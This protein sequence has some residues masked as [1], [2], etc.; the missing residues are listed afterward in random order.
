[1]VRRERSCDS[2]S[3]E[4]SIPSMMMR[5]AEGSTN[6]RKER[7]RVVFPLPV[8]VRISQ[9]TARAPRCECRPV[10]PTMPTFSCGRS[11]I[12]TTSLMIKSTELHTLGLI[13]NETLLSEGGECLAY[14][15]E[16]CSTSI[17]PSRDGQIAGGL[18]PPELSCPTSE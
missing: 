8:S 1:M 7:A 15:T 2:E 18:M 13:W 12:R 9:K 14:L 5:P 11:A 4:M 17:E 3:V 6:L 16:R 10:L